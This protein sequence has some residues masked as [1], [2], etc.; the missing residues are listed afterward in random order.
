M[1]VVRLKQL[2]NEKHLSQKDFAKAMQVSPSTVGMWEQ[3]RNEPSHEMLKLMAD[4]FGVT[5]DYLLG[6]NSGDCALTKLQKALLEGFN[7]LNTEGQNL[8]MSMLG[9]LKMSHAKQANSSGIVQKNS[10]GTNFL[11]TG[12]NNNY[13]IVTP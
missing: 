6:R 2:R 3:G 10:G 12:G 7:M 13:S 11:A 5:T 8:I 9:S 4:Y 1:E